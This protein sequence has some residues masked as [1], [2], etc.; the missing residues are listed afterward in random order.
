MRKK[1]LFPLDWKVPC[2]PA[3]EFLNTPLPIRDTSPGMSPALPGLSSSSA[4]AGKS[5]EWV[6]LDSSGGDPII[7][8]SPLYGPE[9][10][11]ASIA[12]LV[13]WPHFT[14]S[15]TEVP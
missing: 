12:R 11:V 3:Q 7:S 4:H 14:D 2:G 1:Y 9:Q 15:G 10:V 8:W 5:S 13:L 6:T